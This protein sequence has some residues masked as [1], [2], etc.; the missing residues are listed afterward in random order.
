[1][2]YC[3]VEKKSVQQGKIKQLP[4]RLILTISAISLVKFIFLSSETVLAQS[5]SYCEQYARNYAE[6]N[7]RDETLRGA[8]G[9]AAR[10]ALFGAILGDAGAGAAVGAGVGA[11]RGSSRQSSDYNYLF[12]IA[13]DDCMRG[14][15]GRDYRY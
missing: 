15:T 14:R 3:G 10:G 7:S 1:M 12:N 13:Y 5:R 8:A 2:L 6:R 11:I 9:G 4:K